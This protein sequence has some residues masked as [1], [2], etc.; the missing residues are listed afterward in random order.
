MGS[1]GS[2]NIVV[3]RNRDREWRWYENE[4]EAAEC[5]ATDI[6]PPTYNEAL[7][8]N[9]ILRQ[10]AAGKEPDVSLGQSLERRFAMR[11][12]ERR[13][14]SFSESTTAKGTRKCIPL[15]ACGHPGPPI[16][17][18]TPRIGRLITCW[19]CMWKKSNE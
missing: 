16:Y 18:S 6:K 9:E 19:K 1:D 11:E 3:G 5:G 7:I 12:A 13:I 17:I 4:A 2:V 14:V 10:N 15:L 8:I